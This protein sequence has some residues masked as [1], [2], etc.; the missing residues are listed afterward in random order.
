MMNKTRLGLKGIGFGLALLL[1]TAVAP[2]AGASP[3]GSAIH[4]QNAATLPLVDVQ[5]RRGQ[6]PV[7]RQVRRNNGAAVAGA[8]VGAAIIG[9]AIIAQSEAQRREERRRRAYYYEGGDGYYRPYRSN[10]AFYER[11]REQHYY[12]EP[13]RGYRQPHYYEQDQPR[14]YRGNPRNQRT[15]TVNTPDKETPYTVVPC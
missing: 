10:R 1:S 8:L 13:Q 3:L 15:C 5:A 4:L 7:R 2:Q 12:Y 11:Q 14:V 6:R 9:G